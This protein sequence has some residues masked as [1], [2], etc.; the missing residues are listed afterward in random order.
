MRILSQATA[1]LA[2]C[3]AGGVR[4]ASPTSGVMELDLVFP[5]NE[6]YAP[7][8]RLPIVFAYQNPELARALHARVSVIVRNW[9]NM[10]VGG[11]DAQ[12]NL[13]RANLSSRDPFLQYDYFQEFGVEGHWLLT[14]TVSWDN[15]TEHSLAQHYG[16]Q[17]LTT[18]TASQVIHF[19][20]SKSAPEIDLV[21]ATDNK[22][23]PQDLEE[24]QE[25]GLT[26]DVTDTLEVPIWADKRAG[27]HCAEVAESTPTPSPCRVQIDSAA[28][29]SMAAS[30]TAR[31]CL[32]KEVSPRKGLSA[33]QTTKARRSSW[34]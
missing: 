20:T 25:M 14:W 7:T 11:A 31:A 4:A 29:S 13:D 28:V 32:Y 10:G 23:C 6:S 19:S 22:N 12:F 9:D 3:A 34:L 30:M 27:D 8:A 21:A 15:C 5:R 26:F 16:G 1:L 17:R 18:H 24:R 2:A 33:P